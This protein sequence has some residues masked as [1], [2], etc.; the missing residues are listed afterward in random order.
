MD[1]F[2]VF[3]GKGTVKELLLELSEDE[4][5]FECIKQAMTEN[6]IE[7]AGIT[8]IEGTIKK[9]IINYFIGSKYKSKEIHMAK[10]EKAS[11]K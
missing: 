10:I 8:S 6:K 1:N 11:G 3:K 7:N 2:S 9:G 4:S 5:V